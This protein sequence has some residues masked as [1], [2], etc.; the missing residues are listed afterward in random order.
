MRDNVNISYEKFSNMT[1]QFEEE[2][3]ELE[4]LFSDVKAKTK[5]FAEYW[6]GNDS[7]E[8]LPNLEKVENEFEKINTHNKEYFEYL[9]RVLELYKN[10]DS[11]V[12]KVANEGDQSLDINV[13]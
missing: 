6:E 9:K 12:S 3:S 2:I 1:N 5:V 10:Y 11:S 7:D 8:V 4:E 13:N